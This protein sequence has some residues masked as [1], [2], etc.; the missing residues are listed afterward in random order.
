MYHYFW[1][2]FVRQLSL[3][4]SVYGIPAVSARINEPGRISLV[5]NPS[6]WNKRNYNILTICLTLYTLVILVGQFQIFRVN[7]GNQSVPIVAFG[8]T[9]VFVAFAHNRLRFRSGQKIADLVGLMNTVAEYERKYLDCGQDIKYGCDDDR[10]GSDG[11]SL[12]ALYV[13]T[14][15]IPVLITTLLIINPCMPPFPG[16][17]ILNC[18]AQAGTELTANSKVSYENI[19]GVATTTFIFGVG[20]VVKLIAMSTFIKNIP[21]SECVGGHVATSSFKNKENM[22]AQFRQNEVMVKAFNI[23]Y[24][25][26]YFTYVMMFVVTLGILFMYGLLK[27]HE[28]AS[29][30]P[31]VF[32]ISVIVDYFLVVL[33]SYTFAGNIFFESTRLRVTWKR[34]DTLIQKSPPDYMGCAQIQGQLPTIRWVEGPGSKVALYKIEE[35]RQ[36]FQILPKS[37]FGD[38]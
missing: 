22:V 4:T 24:Q 35:K 8:Y 13:G 1:P 21:N 16:S 29:I 19:Q 15:M 10:V 32:I 6:P 9:F 12:L 17:I 36:N 20:T 11:M 2:K 25:T 30:V 5:A 28:K 23:C 14:I 27:F 33:L 3:T 7:H 38:L 18:S 37:I 34:L 26:V 31:L